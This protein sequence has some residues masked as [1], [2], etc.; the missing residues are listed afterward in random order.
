MKRTIDI[1]DL[2]CTPTSPCERAPKTSAVVSCSRRTDVPAFYMDWMLDAIRTGHVDV[3]N[4]RNTHQVSRISLRKQDVRVFAWW[5]KDY[6]TWLD[7]WDN[8]ETHN[9]LSQYEGHMFNFTI[10]TPCELEPM[11]AHSFEDRLA[12]MIRLGREFGPEALMVRFDPI[13]HWRRV[14]EPEV[15]ELNNLAGFEPLCSA[16]E[17][18]GIKQVAV[19]FVI[20]GAPVRKRFRLAKLDP[21][22]KTTMDK[23]A[24]LQDLVIIASAHGVTIRVCSQP[25]LLGKYEGGTIIPGAC[26]GAD[27]VNMVLE[28][29][30]DGARL[31]SARKD[32][33]QREHCNC[34]VSRDIGGYNMQCKHSCI[35]CYAN[36]A[37]IADK[38]KKNIF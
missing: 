23:R 21:I 16:M 22:E 35:Y 26:I 18:I 31:K 19:A 13:V 36:P 20:L 5:S 38:V 7:I 15:G 4:P 11:V 27:R 32:T 24:I 2:A 30:S 10:N 17:A 37:P 25:D 1:E 3:P 33:G 28:G 14:N 34:V 12:Q 6:A 8:P 9:L 29:Q